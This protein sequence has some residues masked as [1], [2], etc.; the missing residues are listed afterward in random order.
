MTRVT[1]SEDFFEGNGAC[2]FPKFLD[3]FD[4][5]IDFLLPKMCLGDNS[6]D[7]PTM[8]GDDDRLTV[9]DLV[10]QS[11]KVGSGLGRPNFACHPE[12][13]LVDPTSRKVASEGYLVKDRHLRPG[14]LAS[15]GYS[16]PRRR[17]TAPFRRARRSGWDLLP[18]QPRLTK[19]VS[20]QIGSWSHPIIASEA[21]QSR[22]DRGSS[23]R[24]CFITRCAPRNDI[25]LSS[26]KTAQIAAGK[27]QT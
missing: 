18:R 9:L 2:V 10:E 25:H 27:P 23:A 21:K 17:S 1:P 20:D 19:A 14:A 7:G 24:D 13:R 16:R 3:V 26:R 12:F 11:R 15:C 22:A 5:L 8:P 6:C 4:R